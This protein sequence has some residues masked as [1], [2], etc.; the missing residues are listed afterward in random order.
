M[1]YITVDY[2]KLAEN[3]E[4]IDKAFEAFEVLCSKYPHAMVDLRRYNKP[5][6]L[7]TYSNGKIWIG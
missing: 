5:T 4:T 1:Y 7:Q 3:L 2:L 6:P